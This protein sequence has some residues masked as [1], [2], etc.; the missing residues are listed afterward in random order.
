MTS[1]QLCKMLMPSLAIPPNGMME[2]D[3]GM[4]ENSVIQMT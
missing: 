4:F 2:T 3:F 1:E